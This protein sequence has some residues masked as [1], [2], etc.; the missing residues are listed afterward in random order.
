MTMSRI[1]TLANVRRYDLAGERLAL[2]YREEGGG[3]VLLLTPL[4]AGS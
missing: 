3:R 2:T 1:S 4:D